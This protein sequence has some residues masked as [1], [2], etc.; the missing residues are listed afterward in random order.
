MM[1]GESLTGVDSREN[2]RRGFRKSDDCRSPSFQEL[3]CEEKQ[4]NGEAPGEESRV[5]E[6]FCYYFAFEDGENVTF[7]I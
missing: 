2:W 4:R 6:L 7:M 3:C 5:N 1:V